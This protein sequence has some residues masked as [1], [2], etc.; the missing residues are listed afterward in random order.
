MLEEKYKIF[1]K[2]LNKFKEKQQQQK[3]RG[4]NDYNLL[5]T[6]LNEHDEVRLHS[7]V[8][9]SLLDINGLHYQKELFLEKFVQILKV[10]EFEFNIHES[11]LFLEYQNIDLYLTDGIKHIIIENKIYALDQENQIK[12][13]YDIIKD[14]NKDLE[15]DDILIIYLSIDRLQ[16]SKYSLGNLTIKENYIYNNSEKI[17]I[18]KS[19]NYKKEILNWL[20]NCLYEIQNITNLNESIQQYKSV[21]EKISNK[22]KGKVMSL[23]EFLLENNNL[24]LAMG[25]EN[26]IKEAKSEIQLLFW[27]E[28]YK[29]LSNNGHQFHFIDSQSNE[30]D[31]NSKIKEY[32]YKNKKYYGLIRKIIDIDDKYSLIF[33][34]EFD[35]N[36][37]FGLGIAENNQRKSICKQSEFDEIKKQIISYDGI[38]WNGRDQEWWI[39]WKYP[40]NKLD[41]YRFDSDIIFDL[42]NE[43][44]RIQIV[45]SLVKEIISVI[46]EIKVKNNDSL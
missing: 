7:R 30:I 14:E 6:V 21:V 26:S 43:K 40:K 28:L 11:K 42:I 4:L 44:K 35:D 41:F 5:T 24:K 25:L 45:E 8:I 3:E 9:S 27:E 20:D 36:I 19:I 23:K 2:E 17:A 38:K 46:N 13:Y 22:Y 34:I 37:A 18:F 31:I 33:Y 16:P 39:C 32:Y 1:F 15:Y 10:D 29:Q 12:R